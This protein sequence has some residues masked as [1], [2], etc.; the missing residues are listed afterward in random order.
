M[1]KTL[2]LVKTT[3][4]D[5][6]RN[7]DFLVVIIMLL[8]YYSFYFP[9]SCKNLLEVSDSVNPLA[10]FTIA[11]LSRDFK[12]ITL[13]G[14]IM[15]IGDMAGKIEDRTFRILRMSRKEWIQ[16]QI[17]SM[18]AGVFLYL[19]TVLVLTIL[20]YVP[21]IS[22]T[23]SWGTGIEDYS[24]FTGGMEINDVLLKSGVIASFFEAFMLVLLLGI[25]FGSICLLAA[26]FGS[27][28]MGPA[29]CAILLVWNLMLKQRGTISSYF[30][31]VGMV[32]N[33]AGGN[34]LYAVFYYILLIVIILNLVWAVNR[35]NDLN[36]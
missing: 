30:S 22:F 8:G 32:E 9:D 2:A 4:F 16:G 17:L 31:P 1:V 19:L 12:L 24:F 35:N 7:F 10:A 33:Y 36:I 20:F 28:K 23:S 5:Q 34:T 6:F 3:M 29:V 21:V 11:F 18:I 26:A 14:L 25:L 15:M 27:K 13:A